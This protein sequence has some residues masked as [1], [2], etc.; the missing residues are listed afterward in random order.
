MPGRVVRKG[1]YSPGQYSWAIIFEKSIKIP[2]R[3]GNFYQIKKKTQ[4]YFVYFE[5]FFCN[6][7]KINALSGDNAPE[8][9]T[10]TKEM[11][12]DCHLTTVTVEG[13]FS[14][15]LVSNILG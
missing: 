5:Y 4:K 6:M 13:H 3:S 1:W 11:T 10:L 12:L 7:V 14:E 8:I 9:T 2:E 15:L